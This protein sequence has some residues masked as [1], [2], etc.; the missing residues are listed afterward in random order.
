MT[1]KI[2]LI[3]FGLLWAGGIAMAT[4]ARADIAVIVN[5][6]NEVAMSSD[7]IKDIFIGKRVRFPSGVRAIPVDQEDGRAIRNEFYS[8][9]AGKDENDMKAY[10]STLIFTGNGRP[11]K[12]L[13]DDKDVMR[14]IKENTSGIGYVSSKAVDA[15]VKV[16]YT[17][18]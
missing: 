1:K 17:V 10:W 14:F 9:L 4:A 6:G 5:A 18:K 15:S 12:V 3:W 16:I 8:L 13:T 11:P 2:K 7:Q